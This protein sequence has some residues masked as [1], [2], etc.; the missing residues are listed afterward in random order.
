MGDTFMRSGGGGEGR[1]GSECA[2]AE[3]SPNFRDSKTYIH[4]CSMLQFT[5]THR[6]LLD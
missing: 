1:W 5:S 2:N 4:L 3:S 6:K